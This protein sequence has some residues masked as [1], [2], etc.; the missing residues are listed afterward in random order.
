MLLLIGAGW[1]LVALSLVGMAAGFWYGL[2]RHFDIWA[3]GLTV[4]L[5][6]LLSPLVFWSADMAEGAAWDAEYA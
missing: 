3:V 5:F 4:A 2:R 1:L 6:G